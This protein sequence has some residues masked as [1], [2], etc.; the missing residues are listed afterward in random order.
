MTADIATALLLMGTGMI[1][2]F[3]VLTLVI[4]TGKLLIRL[5]NRLGP[6]DNAIYPGQLADHP[7]S[8][9][10][11]HAIEKAIQSYSSGKLR[12]IKIQK[13]DK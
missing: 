9:S 3:F 13:R 12:V 11:T 10:I 4:L 6:I 7:V 5:V 2:V 8:P 1:T